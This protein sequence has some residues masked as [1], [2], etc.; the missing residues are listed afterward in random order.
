MAKI[1]VILGDN[2][3]GKTRHLLNYFSE[4]IE[5]KHFAIISNSIINPFPLLKKINHTI[6]D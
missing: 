3:Q 6:L 5:R 1:D 4:N 2:G